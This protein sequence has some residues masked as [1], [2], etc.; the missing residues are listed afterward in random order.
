VASFDYAECPGHACWIAPDEWLGAELAT[1]YPL[2]LV[3]PQPGDKLHSQMECALADARGARPG[4]I[5]INSADAAARGLRDGDLAK[6]FNERGACRA[7]IHVSDEIRAGVVS[8]ST[9][10]WLDADAAG[11]D[12]QG[13][14][15]ILTR[16]LGTSRI[17]QGCSAHTTLVEVVR[18]PA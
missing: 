4:A 8:L 1:R 12:T 18:L 6:V 14:P 10:A 5:E 13:N 2:H 9:G 11:T 16:D 17:G 3:S 7:R 15:N